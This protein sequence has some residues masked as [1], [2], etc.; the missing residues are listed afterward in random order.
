V[1]QIHSATAYVTEAG[2]DGAFRVFQ[3]LQDRGEHAIGHLTYRT[4]VDHYAA[5]LY[6][7]G[8]ACQHGISVAS[9][10]LIWFATA[11][12]GCMYKV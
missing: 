4:K 10:L 6:S 5:D 8:Q 2:S 12:T 11:H 9:P 7:T 3:K 1:E